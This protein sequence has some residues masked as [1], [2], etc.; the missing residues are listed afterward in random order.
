MILVGKLSKAQKKVLCQIRNG[1]IIG[2]LSDKVNGRYELF[3]PKPSYTP[4]RRLDYPF[5]VKTI[6]KNTVFALLVLGLIR[7]DNKVAKSML[8]FSRDI[9]YVLK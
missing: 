7:E 4:C 9:W 3:T 8:P 6:N 2:E 5:Y 1:S